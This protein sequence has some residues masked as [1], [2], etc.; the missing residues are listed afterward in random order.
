[1]KEKN[2]NFLPT[3]AIAPGETIRNEMDFLGLDQKALATRLD[4]ST[5]YLSDILN[6]NEPITDEI[7]MKLERVL[8]PSS[9]FWM[10]LETNYQLDKER[11]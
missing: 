10:N 9:E 8:G 7:A 2:K 1:M 6:G 5:K 3:V 4:I 11:L